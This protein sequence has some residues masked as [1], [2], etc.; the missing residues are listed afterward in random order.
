MACMGL[1]KQLHWARDRAL[2]WAL[3]DRLAA[4]GLAVAANIEARLERWE[5]LGDD[6]SAALGAAL[7]WLL[8]RSGGREREGETAR[9]LLRE[10][11]RCYG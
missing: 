2:L 7:R 10:Y 5:A 6:D 11:E 1:R 4:S 9:E 8:D 3:L